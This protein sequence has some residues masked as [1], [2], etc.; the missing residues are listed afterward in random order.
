MKIL[1]CGGRDFLD[2]SRVCSALERLGVKVTALIHGAARGADTLA[3]NWAGSQGIP[4]KAFP[5]DW[6]KDGIAAGPIRNAKM[7]KEGQPD[8]VV[9]FP[10]GK[11]TWDMVR[12]ARAAKVP[13]TLEMRVLN[14]HALVYTSPYA[15]Y[16]GR[17]SA[18]GNPYKLGDDGPRNYVIQKYEKEILPSLDL[19]PLRLKDLICYCAPLA[20]H[21]DILMREANK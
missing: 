19:Q 17:G 7:L 14:K 9:A 8:L 15:V 12:R 18:W 2:R 5:A 20:C 6:S 16:V 10:G 3:A 1:V 11:G 4:R 21:A 13:V